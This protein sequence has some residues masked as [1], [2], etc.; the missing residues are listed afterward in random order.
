VFYIL[1]SHGVSIIS[2]PFQFLLLIKVIAQTKQK[3]NIYM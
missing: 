3:K 2:I 1:T